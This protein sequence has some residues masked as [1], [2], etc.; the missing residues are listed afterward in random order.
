[1]R[2]LLICFCL[3]LIQPMAFGQGK[4]S[5]AHL[6]PTPHYLEEIKSELTKEWPQ[7]RTINLVFHGH[8][9][10]AGF[11][12]TPIVNTLD[13]YPFQLLG[14][15][16]DRYPHA[17]INA[18]VTAKGGENAHSGQARFVD[19]VLNHQPDI[20]F[21]DYALNDRGIGLEAAKKAWTDMIVQATQRGIKVILLTPSPDMRS[22]LLNPADPLKSHSDQIVELAAAHSVG[23]ADVFSLFQQIDKACNCIEDY[24]SQVN[25]PNQKGHEIIATEILRY[26]IE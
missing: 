17:V 23:L 10:P 25:H 14:L 24:M 1:M 19:E 11:F 13:A 6:M 12:K 2:S 9:V 7:N 15:L 26:F 21:I 3:F 18:I 16:K 22:D 5:N 20:L 8:S 4:P